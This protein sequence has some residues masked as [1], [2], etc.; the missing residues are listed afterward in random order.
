[1]F[2]GGGGT[3]WADCV[4]AAQDVGWSRL[5]LQ[6]GVDRIETRGVGN[7]IIITIMFCLFTALR[8]PTLHLTILWHD[9]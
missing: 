2:D 7:W 5:F 4:E 8:I 1:M 3:S 9:V 6:Q